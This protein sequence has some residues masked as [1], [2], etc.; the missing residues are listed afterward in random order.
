MP[1]RKKSRK[2]LQKPDPRRWSGGLGILPALGFVVH[3]K[4]FAHVF[5]TE[6]RGD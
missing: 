6:P 2:T 5:G 3:V 4:A 1:D